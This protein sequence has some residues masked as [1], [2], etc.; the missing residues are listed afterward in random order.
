MRWQRI[1]A[2]VR[3]PVPRSRLLPGSPELGDSAVLA[4]RRL[5]SDY[6]IGNNRS[7]ESVVC[8]EGVLQ[9][10]SN[11]LSCS[12]CWGYINQSSSVESSVGLSEV[13]ATEQVVQSLCSDAE[14]SGYAGG[15][16]NP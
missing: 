7:R 2:V 14:S 15:L 1:E 11:R 3:S 8:S 16:V 10:R 4:Y 5:M 12:P 6:D 9:D 13:W